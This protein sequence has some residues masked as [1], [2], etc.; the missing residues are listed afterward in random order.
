MRALQGE[1]GTSDAT[2]EPRFNPG[3]RSTIATEGRAGGACRGRVWQDGRLE[4]V[5][6]VWPGKVRLAR[7]AVLGRRVYPN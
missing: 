6:W 1:V 5:K 4:A 3:S 7:P 2:L